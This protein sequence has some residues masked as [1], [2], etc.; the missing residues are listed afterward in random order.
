MGIDIG[1]IEVTEGLVFHIDAGNTRSYSGTGLTSYGLIG[2]IGAT[3][4]NGVGFTSS[5]NG[6]FVFDGS[7]DYVFHNSR[8]ANTEFQYNSA[9]TIMS[10]CKITENGGTGYIVT[11][12]STDGNGT[13]YSGWAL[14]QN[15]GT[16]SGI[17][18]G[19]P[20]GNI[21]SWRWADA[22]TASFNN[23]V[24][25]KW[26][27]ITYINT[28]IAGEQKIYINGVNY[29]SNAYDNTNPPYTINYTG[30]HRICLGQD[31]FGY[32]YLSANIG[33]VQI[34]NRALSATEIFQNYHATKGRYR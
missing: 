8:T 31:S 34:Y 16:V 28:G 15:G 27:H 5:N 25:N 10:Y 17:I 12:R 13:I 2:G 29:T 19:Y 14:L 32:H 20:G 21:V 3:L 24:F 33:Q 22:S 30:N 1:P 4:Y 7:D 9:F 26:A 18:G 11:N 23:L 6:S